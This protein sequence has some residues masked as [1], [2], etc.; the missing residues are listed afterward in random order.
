M[1]KTK[2]IKG[3]KEEELERDRLNSLTKLELLKEVLGDDIKP[4]RIKKI[5]EKTK[6]QIADEEYTKFLNDMTV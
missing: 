5:N 6:E 2:R 3:T 1:R 4:K